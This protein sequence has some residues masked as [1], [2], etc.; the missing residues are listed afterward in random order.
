MN[1]SEPLPIDINSDLTRRFNSHKMPALVKEF[2]FK[3]IKH[4]SFNDALDGL[5]KCYAMSGLEGNGCVLFGDP[6]VGKSRLIRYFTTEI[7]NKSFNQPTEE[8]TPLPILSI[9]VPGRPTITRICEKL[10]QS[11]GNLAPASKSSLTVYTRLDRLIKNQHVEMIIFDEFQHLLRRNALISTRDV[12][13]F[14]KTLMDDHRLTVVFAGLPEAAEL[15]DEYPEIRQRLSFVDISL[16]PF[17]LE[18]SGNGNVF[19]L[20]AYMKSIN[21]ILASLNI[22]ICD[23]ADEDMVPRILLAT[24][25]LPRHITQLFNRVLIQFGTSTVITAKDLNEIYKTVPF[26]T[27]IKPFD[28]F[29]APIHK[30]IEKYN[31]YMRSKTNRSSKETG[32]NRPGTRLAA[33]ES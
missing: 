9:R 24:H 8:L 21:E 16:V 2:Y 7:Y 28:V 32:V 26:N 4:A 19:E 13:A 15:L 14:I 17:N 18:R 1:V 5:N 31:I 25:G 6:G 33:Q 11:A 23:L 27:H 29:T 12:M 10:L 22:N 3:T 20:V 30:V